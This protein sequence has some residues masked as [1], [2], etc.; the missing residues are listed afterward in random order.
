[1]IAK[2]IAYTCEKIEL[3][4]KNES[5]W[6]YLRGI[7][8]AHPAFQDDV[9]SWYVSPYFA[10][11]VIIFISLCNAW[12]RLRAFVSAEGDRSKNYFALGLLADIR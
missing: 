8:N 1:M 11:V 2:E 5:A 7:V 12:D 4:A 6:N 9:V 10:V 3:V